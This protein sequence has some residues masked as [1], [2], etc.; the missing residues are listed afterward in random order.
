MSY[1][2]KDSIDKTLQ[3]KISVQDYSKKPVIAGVQV[4]EIKNMA[5]EDGDFSELIRLTETGE[6][7]G[8]AGFQLRQ[9]NRSKMMPG[10][11]KAWHLHYKQDEIQTVRPEDHLVVGLWDIREESATKGLTMKLVLGGGKSHLLLIPKGV[12]HG[13]MNVSSK[14]VTVLYFVSEQFLLEDPDE[15][16][17]PWDSIK[18][19]WE[20]SHE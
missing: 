17:L 18:G 9:V 20:V 12:A 2:T 1:L 16:R 6:I 8:F 7:E 3:E 19:F 5:G 4:K 14:P 15:R 13:Y 10:A 11:I